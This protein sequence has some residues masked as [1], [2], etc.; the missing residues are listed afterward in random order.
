MV[1]GDRERDRPAHSVGIS[2]SK[3]LSS[4]KENLLA[5][6]VGKIVLVLVGLRKLGPSLVA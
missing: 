2:I 4:E 6:P 3:D 5:S 1:R